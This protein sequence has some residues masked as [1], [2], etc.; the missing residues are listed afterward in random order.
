MLN[1]EKVSN[2]ANGRLMIEQS[3]VEDHIENDKK[4][5]QDDTIEQIVENTLTSATDSSRSQAPLKNKRL[6]ALRGLLARPN[7]EIIGGCFFP[8]PNS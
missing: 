7:G 6:G 1:S 3:A 2:C 8:T 5:V 4:Q